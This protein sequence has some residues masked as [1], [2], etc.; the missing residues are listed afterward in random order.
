MPE[1]KMAN[2]TVAIERGTQARPNSTA[3]GSPPDHAPK[4]RGNLAMTLDPLLEPRLSSGQPG[5]PKGSRNYEWNPEADKLLVE[6]CAKWGAA[7]AKRIMG[8]RIQGCRSADAVPRPDSVRKAVEHR[9]AKLGISKPKRRTPDM[10]KEKHWTE[11][12]TTVLLGALGADA[13]I[14]SIATR[15]GHSV[16]SVRAKIARLDYQ[17][18]EIHGFETFTVSTLADLLRVTPRQIRRWKERG[19]LETKDRRITE[20]CLGRF[21]R[22]H[23]DRIQFDSLP[24]EGQVFLVDLGFPCLEAAAFKKNVREILDGIGRQRKPRR[25]SQGVNATATAGQDE[26]GTD[27][28]DGSA[29]TIGSSAIDKSYS[30]TFNAN[31][32]G[33]V[34]ESPYKSPTAQ[35]MRLPPV[36][37]PQTQAEDMDTRQAKHRDNVARNYAARDM[38]G[39]G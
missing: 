14:E 7:K 38:P 26:E 22:A 1:S 34:V 8:Q 27:D 24:R 11:N 10:R 35:S 6:L 33:A 20:E 36:A 2:E 25:Q 13:T 3:N 32:S 23:P 28:D 29:L 39:D 12:Q 21:L 30:C 9:M 37:I 5:R 4:K 15:T 17:I 16:K 31:G 19:W 18:H